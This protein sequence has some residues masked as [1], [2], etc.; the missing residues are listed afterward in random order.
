MTQGQVI[1]FA[2]VVFGGLLLLQRWID[3]RNKGETTRL[4]EHIAGQSSEDHLRE[5]RQRIAQ[6]DDD[7]R[8]RTRNVLIGL[9]INVAIVGA[10]VL[11]VSQHWY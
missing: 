9:A 10:I 4:A 1:A 6:A 8:H 2:V 3:A 11:V 7:T 5:T